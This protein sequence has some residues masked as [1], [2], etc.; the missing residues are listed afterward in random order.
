MK[1]GISIQW[2]IELCIKEW[3]NDTCH[4]MD[5]PGEK[6]KLMKK[7]SQNIIQL[8]EFSRRGK[9]IETESRLVSA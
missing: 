3:S 5:E 7:A 2:I 4:N 1:S 6:K 8:H 9:F